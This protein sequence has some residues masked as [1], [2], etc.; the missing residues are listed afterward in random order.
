MLITHL[1]N[2][3]K[4]FGAVGKMTYDEFWV[5]VVDGMTVDDLYLHLKTAT[6][7]QQVPLW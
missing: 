6:K 3:P 5:D 2:H 4:L 7:P 1:F